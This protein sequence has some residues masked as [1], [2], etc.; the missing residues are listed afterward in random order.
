MTTGLMIK[1]DIDKDDLL[2]TLSAYFALPIAYLDID[3][4][5]SET[6]LLDISPMT[7]HYRMDLSIYSS[8][9]F[10]TEEIA[11]LVC[12][13]FDTTVLISDNEI[14][15][16]SWILITKDGNHGTVFQRTGDTDGFN[17]ENE[18]GR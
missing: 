7:G 10:N 4:Q 11:I 13:S 15:P 2:S 16:Y 12:Q 17:L 6:I 8:H 1:D 14:N 9:A 3:A 5:Q 18:F